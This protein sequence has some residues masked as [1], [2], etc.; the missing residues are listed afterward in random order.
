MVLDSSSLTN[1]FSAPVR[2]P[3]VNPLSDRRRHL[4][5]FVSAVPPLPSSVSLPPLA[6]SVSPSVSFSLLL[7]PLFLLF[8]PPIVAPLPPG[9]LPQPPVFFFRVPTRTFHHRNPTSK[10]S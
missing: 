5:L 4:P 2:L 3:P 9:V 8:A 1:F 6:S 10:Q 7:S